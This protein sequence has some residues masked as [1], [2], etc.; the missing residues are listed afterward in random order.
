MESCLFQFLYVRCGDTVN[1]VFFEIF[2]LMRNSS[3]KWFFLLLTA[4]LD[5][6]VGPSIASLDASAVTLDAVASCN[7]EAIVYEIIFSIGENYKTKLYLCEC[8]RT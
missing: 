6:K 7:A 1:L 5:I 3:Q 4:S 8:Q 2:I